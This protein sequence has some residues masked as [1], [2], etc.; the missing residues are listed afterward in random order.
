MVMDGMM[1]N[2]WT[3]WH[4]CLSHS[5][6]WTVEGPSLTWSG[7]NGNKGSD[8]PPE[9]EPWFTPYCLLSLPSGLSLQPLASLVSLWPH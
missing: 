8:A 4:G 6:R 7:V 2:S 9:P 5:L 3:V 1:A